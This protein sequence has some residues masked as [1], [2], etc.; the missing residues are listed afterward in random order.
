MYSKGLELETLVG[1]SQICFITQHYNIRNNFPLVACVL[2]MQA[3]F[4]LERHV[5]CGRM[6]PALW[7][8]G[9]SHVVRA[10]LVTSHTN[11]SNKEA[12]QWLGPV[13]SVVASP[14]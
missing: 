10:Y 8:V 7:S 12:L 9:L 3:L 1:W 4:K 14:T 11:A 2:C 13:N 6:I 5:S